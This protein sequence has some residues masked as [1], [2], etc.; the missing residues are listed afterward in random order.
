MAILLLVIFIT[1]YLI[2]NALANPRSSFISPFSSAKSSLPAESYLQS[3]SSSEVYWRNHLPYTVLPRKLHNLLGTSINKAFTFQPSDALGYKIY[4]N[5]NAKP[6]PHNI[7]LFFL[8][9]SLFLGNKMQLNFPIPGNKVQLLPRKVADKFPLT[10]ETV[11]QFS[12]MF[13]YSN[14]Q[15]SLA[16]MT[17]QA[18]SGSPISGERKSC[19]SSLESMVD[20]CVENVGQ[21]VG[22]QAMMN[23]IAEEHNEIREYDVAGYNKLLGSS[24]PLA[25]HQRAFPFAIFYC[26][27]AK[28]SEVYNVSLK[29]HDNVGS[30]ESAV[31][32]ICHKDTHAWDVNHVAFKILKVKPGTSVCHFI[33]SSSVIFM[34]T[35]TLV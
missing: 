8:P 12:T 13:N 22:V 14:E 18:C 11:L 2:P 25:C 27:V 33:D 15:L 28:E 29:R 9:K 35:T 32:V 34:A 21:G 23:E 16:N 17:I 4:V 19:V 7:T 5:S 31:M 26:H 1:N 10:S 3:S 20:V 30:Q 6:S 24:R